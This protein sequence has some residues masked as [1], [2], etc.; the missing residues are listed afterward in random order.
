MEPG[1][2]CE[3]L[4]KAVEERRFG[5][6]K[7]GG[8]DVGM[9]FLQKDGRRAVVFIQGRIYAASLVDLPCII[10]G[11]K[12]WDKKGWWKSADICQMLLVLGK[13]N[14]EEDLPAAERSRA[15]YLPVCAWSD[16]SYALCSEE[17]IQKEDQ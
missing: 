1:E 6:K 16:A 10:E 2:D 11:M 12:S 17:E 14:S 13:V 8:V 7:D 4:R 3:Y 5:L 15:S 9:K